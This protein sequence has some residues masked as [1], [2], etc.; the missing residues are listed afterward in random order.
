M[1]SN[2]I[3]KISVLVLVLINLISLGFIWS[4]QFNSK[5]HNEHRYQPE[6]T[7]RRL[8]RELDLSKDQTKSMRAIHR[9]YR[10]KERSLRTE[11]RKARIDLKN[12]MFSSDMD[13]SIFEKSLKE[14]SS[15]EYQMELLRFQKHKA[16]VEILDKNQRAEFEKLMD[17]ALNHRHRH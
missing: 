4:Q 10:K 1:I 8:A 7:M 2:R 9:K 16:L 13:S 15:L 12:Y 3:L 6:R 11:I 5:D 17:K 14:I